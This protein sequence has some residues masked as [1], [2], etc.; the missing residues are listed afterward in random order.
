MLAYRAGMKL[1]GKVCVVTGGANGI[2]RALCRRFHQ[3][4]ARAIYVADRD[5]AGAAAVAAEIGASAHAVVAD[6]SKEDDLAAL[7]KRAEAEH[8]R[9]DLFVSNAGIAVGGGPEAPDTEWM[10][11]WNVNLMAHVW[12]ARHA[13]PAMLARGEGYLLS[14]ASAAGLLTSIGAAPY[15]VTKHAVVAFAEWLAITYGERGIRVSCLCPLGVKT[16]MLTQGMGDVA[17]KA[18]LASGP[19]LEAEQVAEATVQGIEEERFLILPHPEVATF[20]QRRAQE[21]ERW[22]K[23]MR[24]VQKKLNL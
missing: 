3:A 13:L 4:G 19:V 20:V 1:K 24:G 10:R 7:V 15:A 9:I 18:V 23:G 14:T 2:G 21:H 22:L 11:A 17:I 12:A 8:G 6:V 5:V 16:D